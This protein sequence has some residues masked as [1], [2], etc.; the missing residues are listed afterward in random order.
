[1]SVLFG[2][3]LY[4]VF[5]FGSNQHIARLEVTLD[6]NDLQQMEAQLRQLNSFDIESDSLDS[7]ENVDQ[8][9]LIETWK[10]CENFDEYE[11]KIIEL[12]GKTNFQ[13]NWKYYATEGFW[14]QLSIWF[15]LRVW[16]SLQNPESLNVFLFFVAMVIFFLFL[17]TDIA[18]RRARLLWYLFWLIIFAAIYQHYWFEPV[19][20][21][22]S[23]TGFVSWFSSCSEQKEEKPKRHA[24][25]WILHFISDLFEFAILRFFGLFVQALNLLPFGP[26]TTIIVSI[27]SLLFLFYIFGGFATL[28]PMFVIRGLSSISSLF[29]RFASEESFSNQASLYDRA[30]RRIC[31]SPS[32]SPNIQLNIQLSP[33]GT[34]L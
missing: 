16:P 18:N 1:M 6:Q 7:I 29:S 20:K 26:F 33:R 12:M 22:K 31:A 3:K 21:T 23:C 10:F 2:F 34:K 17:I 32:L 15:N 11:L 5:R 8:K 30:S 4:F 19:V 13:N 25:K 24:L 28:I 14:R 9:L 27:S